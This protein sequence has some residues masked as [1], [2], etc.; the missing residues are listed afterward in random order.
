MTTTAGLAR[1]SR[2]V[3]HP[4]LCAVV[5]AGSSAVHLWLA[6]TSRHGA[7][8]GA[9]ML[10]LAVVCLPC[11]VHI[12]EHSRVAAL[13][14]V[15]ACAVGMVALHG[16]LLAAGGAGGH[17]HGGVPASDAPS[18]NGAAGLLLVIALEITTALLAA[19]LLA[20]LRRTSP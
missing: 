7:W 14:R 11:V 5:V 3:L 18:V 6:A 2:P 9:L 8:L 16:L 20:R 17:A 12:W 19:T 15:M 10:V 1:A 4:R 13:R